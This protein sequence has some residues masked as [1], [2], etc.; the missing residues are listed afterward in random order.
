MAIELG[1]VQFW[2]ELPV[3]VASNQTCTVC[4]FDFEITQMISDHIA[5]YSVAQQFLVD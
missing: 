5:I 4:S 3:H 2:S 1:V